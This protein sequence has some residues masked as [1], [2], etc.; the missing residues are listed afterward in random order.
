MHQQMTTE[1]LDNKSLDKWLILIVDDE[2]N[3]HDLLKIALQDI[4]YNN[5]KTDFISAY[6]AAQAREII[7]SHPEIAVII[8]DVMMEEDDAGLSF[9]K[10]VREEVKNADTR[11]LLH[12]GQPGIAPKKEVSVKY[13][14][15]GYLDKNVTDNDDC[16]VATQLA[17]QS[18]E[19]RLKLK[20]MAAKDDLGLLKEIATIY[21]SL[22]DDPEFN[23]T[24]ETVVGKVNSMVCLSQ[25]IL[26]GY[27]LEDLKNDLNPGSTKE[28]R[29]SFEDYFALIQT[30]DIKMILVHTSLEKYKKERLTTFDML[31]QA[32]QNFC[33]IK[34]LPDDSK[35][36]L[37]ARIAL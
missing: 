13:R 32:A 26:A 27:A 16:Y 14:I 37:K 34:I 7:K 35:Q 28:K 25:E 12:T 6:T 19:E 30:H 9:V 5:K 24:Y 11:I 1:N 8:L 23:K 17:L 20:E 4:A 33:N 10:F 31:L 21:T 36:L 22:L 2:E 29:L 3:I 18:Y 15:D